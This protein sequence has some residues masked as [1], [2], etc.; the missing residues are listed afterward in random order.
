MHAADCLRSI[1]KCGYIQQAFK[2]RKFTETEEDIM[3]SVESQMLE[4]ELLSAAG[5]KDLCS[6]IVGGAGYEVPPNSNSVV[7]FCKP[8]LT[9]EMLGAML[10][11]FHAAYAVQSS[12]VEAY[13]HLRGKKFKVG[14]L[15][16]NSNFVQ[17]LGAAPE[18][19]HIHSTFIIAQ[20]VDG[21]GVLIHQDENGDEI[22]TKVGVGDVIVIPA[23]ALHFF[24]GDPYVAY[25]GIEIGPVIDRQKHYS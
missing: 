24:H 6:I 21:C 8:Q 9:Q 11:V 12:I 16:F 19:M 2:S 15:R 18:P 17:V 22:R 4:A 13:P 23:G 14:D 5:R 20:V 1:K 3:A 7:R 10:P 25:T